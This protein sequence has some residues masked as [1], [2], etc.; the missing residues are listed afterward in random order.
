MNDGL[1]IE[2]AGWIGFTESGWR[3][4]NG[5][6]FMMSCVGNASAIIGGLS[7]KPANDRRNIW[8]SKHRLETW[9]RMRIPFTPFPKANI[10]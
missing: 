1:G 4:T 7:L 10:W 8:R 6:T 9:N 2:K 3:R 5:A